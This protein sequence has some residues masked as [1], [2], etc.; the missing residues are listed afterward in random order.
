MEKMREFSVLIGGKAGDGI[1]QSG[2]LISHLLSQLGYYI[3]M[4]FDYPSLIRGGHNFSI[5]RASKNKI[6]SHSEKVDF[7]LALNQETIDLHKNRLEYDSFI[8]YDSDMV[9]SESLPD[10]IKRLGIPLKEIISEEK[11]SPVMRN[12]ILLGA[13]SK[14]LG[15]DW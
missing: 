7:L 11:A 12:S 10:N 1:N 9:E 15:F 13:F 3:Y 6:G 4:Y 2:L 14:S 5:I 8:I